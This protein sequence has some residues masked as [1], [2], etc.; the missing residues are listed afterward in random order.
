MK[1]LEFSK[2]F[3][4]LN[5]LIAVVWISLSYCLAALGMDSNSDVTVVVVTE[6]LVVTLGYLLYQFG[7]KNSRNKYG[8][9]KNGVPY[10]W[11]SRIDE[12]NCCDTEDEIYDEST[13]DTDDCAG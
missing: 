4:L 6:V 13:A 12:A 5:W 9:D 7:L 11:Q 10:K 3:L 8:I 2:L 1:K